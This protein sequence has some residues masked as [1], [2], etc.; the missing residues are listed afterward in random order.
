M[1]KTYFEVELKEI[2][3]TDIMDVTV[4]DILESKFEFK[5]VEIDQ[6]SSWFQ[7]IKEEHYQKAFEETGVD[8]KQF[9]KDTIL[10]AIV[11]LDFEYFKSRYKEEGFVSEMFFERR[12]EVFS[13]NFYNLGNVYIGDGLT[14]VKFDELSKY[15]PNL[16]KYEFKKN[17]IMTTDKVLELKDCH[18]FDRL[19]VF[20]NQGK[21]KKEVKNKLNIPKRE[22]YSKVLEECKEELIYDAAMNLEDYEA[23]EVDYY[24]DLLD[25]TLEEEIEHIYWQK[26]L[27]QIRGPG[28]KMVA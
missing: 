14:F 2:F 10:T 23:S 19:L 21:F 28:I 25:E 24:F 15:K 5:D 16:I 3:I 8:F 4:K 27:E 6:N 20:V 1:I 13:E 18:H 22:L 9:H 26:V 17:K 7:E 11:T 12:S